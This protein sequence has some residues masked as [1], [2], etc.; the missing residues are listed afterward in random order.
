MWRG[1]RAS[2]LCVCQAVVACAKSGEEHLG[3]AGSSPF[4]TLEPHQ[5]SY[6]TVASLILSPRTASIGFDDSVFERGTAKQGVQSVA[7]RVSGRSHGDRERAFFFAF[8]FPLEPTRYDACSVVR[9]FLL[10]LFRH[11]T[12]N[13]TPTHTHTFDPRPRAAPHPAHAVT[14]PG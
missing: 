11:D 1:T 7:K 12:L 9:M 2:G 13:D 6:L 8:C 5:R 14:T 3:R 4:C 10:A